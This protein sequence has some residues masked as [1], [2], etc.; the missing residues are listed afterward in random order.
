M[1]SEDHNVSAASLKK[2]PFT[3][4]NWSEEK[5]KATL[6]QICGLNTRLK[7]TEYIIVIRKKDESLIQTLEECT[8]GWKA[9]TTYVA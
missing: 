9:H 7:M 4:S 6:R 1:S 5:L 2:I 8:P 3:I